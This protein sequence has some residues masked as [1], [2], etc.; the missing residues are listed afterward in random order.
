[1]RVNCKFNILFNIFRLFLKVVSRLTM[2]KVNEG[3]DPIVS[4]QF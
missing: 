4:T 1:M 2:K 3:I